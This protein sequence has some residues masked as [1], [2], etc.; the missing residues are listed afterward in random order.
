MDL[1]ASIQDMNAK[2]NMDKQT[3]GHHHSDTNGY[4]SIRCNG[5]DKEIDEEKPKPTQPVHKPLGD[6]L[7]K[8]LFLIYL[9][10]LQGIPLGL[11][12]S[13]PFLLSARGFSYSDQGTFSFAFWPFS[14]KIFWAPLVDSLYSKRI[15]RRKSWLVPVQFLMALFLFT[16]ADRVQS[17]INT[18]KTRGDIM[19]LTF[20]F[21]VFIT[22]AATQDIAVDGWAIS[23]LSK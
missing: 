1:N 9:Y 2:H 13:M 11:C 4:T 8:V 18:G 17:L 23:M 19:F 14:L 16:C 6:D 12:A 20:V 22:L 7:R 10:F 15:G 21:T 3:N 5:D